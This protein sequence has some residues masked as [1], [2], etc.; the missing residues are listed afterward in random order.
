MIAV[1][2]LFLGLLL[3]LLIVFIAEGAVEWS[4]TANYETKVLS[5]VV[6]EGH[7]KE[8]RGRLPDEKTCEGD[9]GWTYEIY[10]QRQDKD[11]KD[12]WITDEKPSR[13]GKLKLCKGGQ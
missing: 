1:V 9:T 2:A 10:L 5:I 3:G 11:H 7:E 12:H 6:Q 4:S 8:A 13:T